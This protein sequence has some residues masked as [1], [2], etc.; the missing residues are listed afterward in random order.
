M[1]QRNLY[2]T[3]PAQQQEIATAKQEMSSLWQQTM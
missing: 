2:K 1:K 3:K